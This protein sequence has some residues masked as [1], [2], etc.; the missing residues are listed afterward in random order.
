MNTGHATELIAELTARGLYLEPKGQGTL[1]IGPPEL[2]DEATVALVR[3]MKSELLAVLLNEGIRSWPCSRCG[4]FAFRLPT[5]CFW[6]RS[7]REGAA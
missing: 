4:R 7:V 6:C 2:L 1:R 5:I 3:T